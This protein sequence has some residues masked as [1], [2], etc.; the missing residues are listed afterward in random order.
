MI[1]PTRPIVTG[2]GSA[3]PSPVISSVPRLPTRASLLRN[4]SPKEQSAEDE[5]EQAY[6]GKNRA[7]MRGGA[8]IPGGGAPKPP[9]PPTP[10][11]APTPTRTKVSPTTGGNMNFNTETPDP[12]LDGF[13]RT[14][15]KPRVWDRWRGSGAARDAWYNTFSDWSTKGWRDPKSYAGRLGTTTLEYGAVNPFKP[16]TAQKTA[17]GKLVAL[18]FLTAQYGMGGAV[19]LTVNEA[20]KQEFLDFYKEEYLAQGWD[21]ETAA[22]L[23]EEDVQTVSEDIGGTVFKIVGSAAAGLADAALVDAQF[24]GSSV[25][26]GGAVAGPPGAAAAGL[27]AAGVAGASALG[28]LFEGLFNSTATLID[29]INGGENETLENNGVF[30]DLPTLDDF[31]PTGLGFGQDVKNLYIDENKDGINTDNEQTPNPYYLPEN[32]RTVWGTSKSPIT[33]AFLAGQETGRVE[34][35]GIAKLNEF[36]PDRYETKAIA[37]QERKRYLEGWYRRA[38]SGIPD[39]RAQELYDLVNKGYFVYKNSDGNWAFEEAAADQYL[40]DT[41]IFKTEA[42]R[43]KYLNRFYPV[44]RW[45]KEFV[46]AGGITSRELYDKMYDEYDTSYVWYGN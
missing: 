1:K 7:K 25:A 6:L 41:S 45:G 32:M 22:F 30:I 43:M 13:D 28:N 23:A 4:A 39:P 14:G 27:I 46:T 19:E 40:A 5:L 44:D 20:K 10:T 18:T 38:D 2:A 35:R 17:L 37:D 16:V 24:I 36:D 34:N 33:S 11:G 29:A 31:N 26:L 12:I 9:T 21:E 8:P 3:N 42:D 15:Q